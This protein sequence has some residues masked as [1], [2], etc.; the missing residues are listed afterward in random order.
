MANEKIEL[1]IDELDTVAGGSRWEIDLIWETIQRSPAAYAKYNEL[2]YRFGNLDDLKKFFET[3]GFDATFDEGS[4]DNKYVVIRNGIELS[5]GRVMD[6][7]W[8][9]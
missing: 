4:G 2:G 8:Y 9:Y 6:S 1:K 3:M 5:H 7:I